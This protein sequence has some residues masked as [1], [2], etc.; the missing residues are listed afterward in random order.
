MERFTEAVKAVCGNDAPSSIEEL[1]DEVAARRIPESDGYMLSPVSMLP[2]MVRDLMHCGL[3]RTIELTESTIREAN[4]Q[5][6]SSMCLLSRAAL[7]TVCLVLDVSE[8]LK[9]AVASG[10]TKQLDAH[11]EFIRKATIGGRDWK[12]SDVEANNITTIIQRLSKKWEGTLWGFY[13]QLSEFAHPNYHGML[14]MYTTPGK[15]QCVTTFVDRREKN[16]EAATTAA[17][18]ALAT[19]LLLLRRALDLHAEFED[20]LVLLAE[21]RGFETGKWPAELPYPLPRPL[22]WKMPGEDS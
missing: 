6:I 18:G 22:Q 10:D 7:E 13:G 2:A 21:K 11:Y 19:S 16:D 1:L 9:E 15:P 4:R 14:A 17:L 12:I 5:S 3:R 20:D 8:K